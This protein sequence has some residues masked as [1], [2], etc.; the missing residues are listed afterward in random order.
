MKRISSLTSILPKAQS[1]KTLTEAI[2]TGVPTELNGMQKERAL[3]RLLEVGNPTQVDKSLI[4][5]MESITKYVVKANETSRFPKDG[6]YISMLRGYEI[7]ADTIE[8]VDKCITIVAQSQVTMPYPMLRKRLAIMATLVIKPSGEGENDMDVR[9]QSLARSLEEFP[10]DIVS[11]A[12]TQVER[13]Q[14]FWPS[15][16][17]FYTHIQSRLQRREYLMR[18]LLKLRV[19]MTANLQ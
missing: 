1:S 8:D 13:T 6:G 3:T 4:S 15:F 5:S 18:D 10:A 2:G 7:R 14:K 9:M 11:Y 12:I 17:E 19:D 16:A